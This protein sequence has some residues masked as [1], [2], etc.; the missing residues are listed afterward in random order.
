MLKRF[1]CTNDFFDIFVDLHQMNSISQNFTAFRCSET[2]EWWNWQTRMIK[3]HVPRGVGVQVP[4]RPPILK[5]KFYDLVFLCHLAT[6][7]ARSSRDDWGSSSGRSVD[8]IQ[9][10]NLRS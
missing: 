8:R 1:V 6:G 7:F 10:N 2:V 5:T 3:G 9:I 4:L